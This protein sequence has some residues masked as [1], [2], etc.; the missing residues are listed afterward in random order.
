MQMIFLCVFEM[1]L[2]SLSKKWSWLLPLKFFHL[3]LIN[4][5]LIEVI[6]FVLLFYVVFFLI[7]NELLYKN[8]Q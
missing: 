7:C 8:G 6:N 1:N 5:T 4:S 3:Y 2:A